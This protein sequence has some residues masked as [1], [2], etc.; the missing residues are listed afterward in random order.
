METTSRLYLVVAVALVVVA[1]APLAAREV[2]DLGGT[3]LRAV[4]TLTEPGAMLV[5]GTVLA[6]AARMLNRR[7]RSA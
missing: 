2:V 3:A 5:W 7:G 1:S 6:G 4:T